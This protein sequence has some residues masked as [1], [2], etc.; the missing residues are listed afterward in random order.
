MSLCKERVLVVVPKDMNYPNSLR[1]NP[2]IVENEQEFKKLWME[3]TKQMRKAFVH[4]LKD[5]L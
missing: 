1:K 2:K 5:G 4:S 3:V